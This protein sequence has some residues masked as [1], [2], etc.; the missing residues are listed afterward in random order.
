MKSGLGDDLAIVNESRGHK[1]TLMLAELC[2]LGPGHKKDSNNCNMKSA[3]FL[4]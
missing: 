2:G 3:R 4:F 1:M